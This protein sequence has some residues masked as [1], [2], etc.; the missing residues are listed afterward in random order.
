MALGA[1]NEHGCKNV[2]IVPVGLNYFQR[3]KFRSEVIVEYGRAFE[4]PTEW[5]KEFT[6]NKRQVTENLLKEI[7]SRM[8]SV[9]LRAPT[10]NELRSI[11]MLRE[12]YVPKEVKLT[13]LQH[14]ELCKRFVKGY[15]AV[16]DE[17]EVKE[18]LTELNL[19]IREIDEIGITDEIVKNNYYSQGHIYKDSLIRFLLFCLSVIIGFPG[20]CIF[21]PIGVYI[22]SKAESERIAALKK[23]PNKIEAKDVVSSVKVVQTILCQP[24]I[25][26]LWMIFFFWFKNKYLYFIPELSF[27][28]WT[29]LGSVSYPVYF[30]CK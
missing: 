14:S 26:L 22:K 24:L 13:P 30:Y 10:F 3:E 19:Y 6:T 29:I 8:K 11:H 27:V 25:Y 18:I 2:Q 23:N 15:E 5:A 4:V 21:A 28:V 17:P 20:F 9:T 12:I 16:K 7:E 1:M